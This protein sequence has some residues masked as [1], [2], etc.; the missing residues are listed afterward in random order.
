MDF[1]LEFRDDMEMEPP[2]VEPEV[3]QEQSGQ[4]SPVSQTLP[5]LITPKTKVRQAAQI[6]SA[7]PPGQRDEAMAWINEHI[8]ALY[9]TQVNEVLYGEERQGIDGQMESLGE[10]VGRARRG[11]LD[12]DITERSS[13]KASQVTQRRNDEGKEVLSRFQDPLLGEFEILFDLDSGFSTQIRNGEIHI[14]SSSGLTLRT[15]E[16]MPDITMTLISLDLGTGDVKIVS[17][18]D[19]GEFE[20][21]IL[22]EMLREY[23]LKG[24]KDLGSTEGIAEQL[25]LEVNKDGKIAL[26]ESWMVD[27]L[28]DSDTQLTAILNGDSILIH[29]SESILVDVLGPDYFYI[30]AV[31]YNFDSASVEIIYD[32]SQGWWASANGAIYGSLT[33]W[34][35]NRFIRARLPED[36]KEEG[37]SPARDSRLSENFNELI[38]NFASPEGG[39]KKSPARNSRGRRRGPSQASAGGSPAPQGQEQAPAQAQQ[40]M[41]QGQTPAEAEQSASRAPIGEDNYDLVYAFVAG[42]QPAHLGVEK[43]KKIYAERNA[44]EIVIGAEGGLFLVSERAEWARGLRLEAI[45][46]RVED[47]QIQIDATEEVGEAIEATLAALIRTHVLP[48]VPQVARDALGLPSGQQPVQEEEGSPQGERVMYQVDVDGVGSI[49]VMGRR[50]DAV[51][52]AKDQRFLTMTSQYGLRLDVGGGA[53]WVPDLVLGELRYSLADGSMEVSGPQGA[54]ALDLGPLTEKV[55][56]AL[57]RTQLMP[58]VPGHVQEAVGLGQGAVE[59]AAAQGQAVAAGRV[60]VEKSLGS[61]GKVDV[62]LTDGDSLRFAASGQQVAIH[63][64]HGLLVRMPGLNI[65][66]RLFDLRYDPQSQRVTSRSEPPLG[67]YEEALLGSAVAEYVLPEV[68]KHLAAHDEDLGD[69]TTVLYKTEIEGQGTLKVCVESGDAVELERNDKEISLSSRQGIFWLADGELGDLLPTNRIRR[70]SMSLEDGQIKID[71]DSDIGPL[72]E[73]IAGRLVQTMVLPRLDEAQRLQ[74]FGG[75]DPLQEKTGRMPRAGRVIIEQDLGSLG[76]VDVSLTDGDTIGFVASGE[77]VAISVQHG[78]L[79]RM[80]GLGMTVRLFDLSYDPQSGQVSSRSEPPLG[81]YEEALLSR[82]VAQYVMPELRRYMAT[83]DEDLSDDTTVLYKAEI[84]GQGTVKICVDAGDALQLE[85]NDKEIALSSRQGIYWL[86]DG[87]LGDILPQNRIRRIS[88][89]LEDGQ[90]KIDAD[91]DFGPLAEEVAERLVQSMVLPELDEELRLQLFGGKDPLQ[92]EAALPAAGTVIYEGEAGGMGFDVSLAGDGR[93]Q[94]SSRPNGE[95]H[96]YGG[97]GGILLRVPKVGLALRLLEFGLDPASMAMTELLTDPPVGSGEMQ[98]VRR[99]IEK[100]APE[101][102]SE[103]FGAPVKRGQMRTVA[104]FGGARLQVKPGDG[105]VMQRTDTHLTVSA[106]QGILVSYDD[107]SREPLGNIQQVC[108]ELGTGRIHIDLVNTADR[109]IYRE[110]VEVSEFT[111]DVISNLA[112][113]LLDP[114]LTPG[115]R[116]LGLAGEESLENSPGY[117]GQRAEEGVAWLDIDAPAVGKVQLF[118]HKDEDLAVQADQQQLVVHASRGARVALPDLGLSQSFTTLRYHF[119]SEDFEVVG[120]GKAENAIAGELLKPLVAPLMAKATGGKLQEGGPGPVAQA[121][122][123]LPRNGDREILIEGEGVTME[124]PP[125]AA[126]TVR[127]SGDRLLMHWSERIFIDGPGWFIGNMYFQALSYQFG[128]GDVGVSIEQSNLFSAT[129]IARKEVRKAMKKYVEQYLPPEMRAQGYDFFS[130]RNRAANI[131][132]VLANFQ[133]S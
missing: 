55:L 88:L 123:Q 92:S 80:Q 37:Y 100:F 35:G 126:L 60:L 9:A 125:S 91:A 28:M 1:D 54:G 22:G 2:A 12:R 5:Q 132:K 18:P 26:Y 129:G 67:S 36:M 14:V 99:L 93:L 122:G 73:K 42:G 50:D 47:G 85:R 3:A 68:K 94:V 115:L 74:I 107:L 20:E 13:N 87:E 121:L 65:Y 98:L 127:L 96:V 27:L 72:I 17:D 59:Q 8:G 108:Y 41:Q 110:R 25:G 10:S 82:A 16:T 102:L 49:S 101:A 75:Q 38:A 128:T 77:K 113:K 97:S 11:T 44:E 45:R 23:A 4:S 21:K 70:I 7:M 118:T 57:V 48:Q 46:Y 32:T 71:A 78:L 106:S 62:S 6:V 112:R 116:Q 76:L 103:H 58:T 52:V 34:F 109:S 66:A 120:L 39:K 89:S 19:I 114:Y 124:I 15:P 61:L 69:G 29:F 51:R 64:E 63:V 105:L 86:V 40:Q 84:E 95:L 83:H 56:E 130:D 117:E 119:A 131:Q 53:S 133:G 81:E 43:G 111:E 31:K 90:I 79:V 24:M 33:E 30:T 104:S